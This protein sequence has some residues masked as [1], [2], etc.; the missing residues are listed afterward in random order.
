MDKWPRNNTWPHHAWEMTMSK[1]WEAIKGDPNYPVHG[2][3]E[4]NWIIYC[5]CV[6]AYRWWISMALFA[7]IL[8]KQTLGSPHSAFSSSLAVEIQAQHRPDRLKKPRTGSVGTDR[9]GRFCAENRDEYIPR[10]IYFGVSVGA[11]NEHWSTIVLLSVL[12]RTCIK[13]VH[14]THT[15]V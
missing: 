12:V 7:S 8:V 5:L 9:L 3:K 13:R 14:W 6:N 1:H 11:L 15:H 10:G 2:N 4:V